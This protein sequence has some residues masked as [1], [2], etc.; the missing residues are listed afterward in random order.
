MKFNNVLTTLCGATVLILSLISCNKKEPQSYTT[1]REP[2][3]LPE[4]KIISADGIEVKYGEANTKAN[5]T[6]SVDDRLTFEGRADQNVTLYFR[7]LC[8]RGGDRYLLEH[9]YPLRR[10]YKVFE[11]MPPEVF[12]SRNARPFENTNCTLEISAQNSD[13]S[14]HTFPAL[15]LPMAEGGAE[16]LPLYL[17]TEKL[18]SSPIRAI[19]YRQLQEVELPSITAEETLTF[20]CASFVK[21]STDKY[22]RNISDLK[23]IQGHISGRETRPQY[24]R[25]IKTRNGA[26]VA[27]SPFLLVRFFATEGMISVIDNAHSTHVHNT[28]EVPIELNSIPRHRLY[29]KQRIKNINRNEIHI[30]I[31]KK[32]LV[33][34]EYKTLSGVAHSSTPLSVVP[35]ATPMEQTEKAYHFKLNRNESLE[36]SFVHSHGVNCKSGIVDTVIHI[37]EPIPMLEIMNESFTE[38]WAETELIFDSFKR[39]TVQFPIQNPPPTVR[40]D[41]LCYEF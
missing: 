19:S 36:V 28:R 3:G 4:P 18:S 30:R 40:E 20:H 24:C 10:E 5:L 14:R 2:W 34:T 39:Y 23:F 11:F 32:V 1:K 9:S 33:T 6:F 15:Y 21:A 31:P 16:E 17:E 22:V 13:R 37:Q 38:K 29:L 26:P 27:V 41:R 35:A 8:S 7:T 12:Y 25:M